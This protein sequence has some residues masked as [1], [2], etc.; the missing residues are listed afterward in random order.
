MVGGVVA[1]AAIEIGGEYHATCLCLPPIDCPDRGG[2]CHLSSYNGTEVHPKMYYGFS[3]IV[4][5]R[6]AA[7]MYHPRVAG[8]NADMKSDESYRDGSIIV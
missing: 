6:F 7:R 4:Y 2:R 1:H 8:R 3:P 5:Q